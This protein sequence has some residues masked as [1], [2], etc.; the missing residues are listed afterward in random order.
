MFI[1]D[2]KKKEIYEIS[3]IFLEMFIEKYKEMCIC[4]AQ[5]AREN[6]DFIPVYKTCIIY[7]KQHF[8]RM[9]KYKERKHELLQMRLIQ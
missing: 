6:K 5:Y 7:S 3:L 4:A 2:L 9:K 1:S 8:E